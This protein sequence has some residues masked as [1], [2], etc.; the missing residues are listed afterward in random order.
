MPGSILSADTGFPYL[1][2]EHTAQ[3]KIDKIQSYLYMLLEQLRYT[4][5]NLDAENFNEEGL[6]DLAELITE[7]VYARLEDE[8]GRISQLVLDTQ[9]LG[10]RVSDAEGNISSLVLA[11]NAMQ[12]RISDAEGNIS[13]LT[14]TSQS[15]QSQITGLDG[16]VSE[17][18]QTVNGITLEVTNKT[19][20]S[21]LQLLANGVELSS[22]TIRFTGDVV[23]ASDLEEGNTIISGD[24]ITTGTIES[25]Y[26]K[27]NQL[28]TV[29]D[30]SDDVGGYVG[31][32]DSSI[33][34]ST[35]MMISDS[36]Y[37]YGLICSNNGAKMA[38]DGGTIVVA[39]TKITVSPTKPSPGGDYEFYGDRFVSL[40]GAALGTSSYPWGDVYCADVYITSAGRWL[41]ELF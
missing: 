11:S 39:K 6:N 41:S 13:T 21:K 16:D 3:E 17:I 2:E 36:T 32:T 37:H 30:D 35:A 15:L 31:W 33:D 18:S 38:G 10:A 12:T 23:F 28:L 29:Y 14:Q 22:A 5:G 27:L 24:C 19:S 40:D 1:S 26:I 8:E 4:L 7:P 20:S 25:D 9:G 34:E